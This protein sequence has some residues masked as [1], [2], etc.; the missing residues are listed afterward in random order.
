MTSFQMA[1]STVTELVEK[2]M[3]LNHPLLVEADVKVGVLM[4]FNPDGGAIKHAGYPA[5]ACV[6]VVSLKDR[7]TKGFDVEMMIDQ[8]EWNDL[9]ANQKV[10]VVDHELTHVNRVPNSPK[11]I[12]AGESAWKTDDIDR[13]MI[14]LRKGDINIGDGF[15]DVIARHGDDAV[16]YINIR[17][18]IAFANGAKAKGAEK[19]S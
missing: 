10:A 3:K 1:D 15:A 19:E 9:T 4:C 5:L 11:A 18:G 12:K 6:K 7:I 16:E 8:S 17:R 13:P 14:K 2:I